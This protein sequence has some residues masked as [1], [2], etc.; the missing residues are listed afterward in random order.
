MVIL[1]GAF[2]ANFSVNPPKMTSLARDSS[3]A[4]TQ[5][6]S[7]SSFDE[8]TLVQLARFICTSGWNFFLGFMP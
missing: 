1:L 2:D 5:N 7:A 6:D 4:F 8:C 3:F